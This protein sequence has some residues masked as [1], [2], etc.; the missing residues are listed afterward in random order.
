[1]VLLIAT[2]RI[3]SALN[4]IPE[5]SREDLDLP[6][7]LDLHGPIAHD[8]LLRLSKHL[9]S[10]TEY[11]SSE[12]GVSKDDPT[13]LSAL[14]RGTKVY[15]PPPPKK[16]EPVRVILYDIH[17]LPMKSQTNTPQSPEYLA[18]KAR[19]LAEAEK[20]AYQRLLN[21]TYKPNISYED[22]HAAPNGEP[23]TEDALTPSLVLNIFLSV[24]ITGFAVYWGLTSF[25]MPRILA[26]IFTSL[27]GPGN[28]K[29]GVG[30]SDAVKILLSLLAALTVAVAESVLYVIY[31][32]RVDEA[33][34]VERAVREKKVDLGP[35]DEKD[36]EVSERVIGEKEEI[37]GKG[38]NG[39]MR[40][41]VREK[42]EK[43]N[44][45]ES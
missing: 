19:L 7:S 21:P 39:G 42:W 30:A 45:Q 12:C 33:K 1:M 32:G 34:K 5:S 6:T 37:W 13:I 20:Q 2:E 35:L 44:P 36:Q 41:R 3:I 23:Y 9:K 11:D 28:E 38:V 8:Q 14:L 15:I 43:E 4:A 22:R 40:R 26:Y 29:E 24:I 27:T 10:D 25:G 16:P 18:S 17:T 31:L